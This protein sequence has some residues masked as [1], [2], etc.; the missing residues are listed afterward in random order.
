VGQINRSSFTTH[1][2]KVDTGTKIEFS[3]GSSGL[4]TLAAYSERIA[5]GVAGP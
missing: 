4:A 1:Q 3:F 2:P 5:I